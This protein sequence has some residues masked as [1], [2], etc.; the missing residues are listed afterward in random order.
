MD[1]STFRPSPRL[2][3]ELRLHIWEACLRPS[4]RHQPGLHYCTIGN[5]K[6]LVPLSW[7]K[8]D[9]LKEHGRANPDHRSACLWHAGLW[10][11]CKES[12]AIIMEHYKLKEWINSLDIRQQNRTVPEYYYTNQYGSRRFHAPAMINVREGHDESHLTVCPARDVF[13]VTSDSCESVFWSGERRNSIHNL[14]FATSP[15]KTL[16]VESFA[17]EFMF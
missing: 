13:C 8:F 10:T 6:R 5:D 16:T 11:A 12:R 2:P 9:Q 17:M 3:A 4:Q 7:G 15:S 14:P 1:F